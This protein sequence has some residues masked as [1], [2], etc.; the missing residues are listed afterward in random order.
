MSCG[1]ED[2]LREEEIFLPIPHSWSGWVGL[3]ARRGLKIPSV[4][5]LANRHFRQRRDRDARHI[6]YAAVKR[7]VVCN[8]VMK[9]E[10]GLPS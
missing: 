1:I 5:P 8:S 6:I 2:D 10:N 4:L 7:A 3:S 9:W